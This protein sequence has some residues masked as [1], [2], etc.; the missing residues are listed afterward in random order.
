VPCEHGRVS[1]WV[2]LH[3]TPLTPAVWDSVAAHL[4]GAVVSPDCTRVPREPD[5][6]RLL[7]ETVSPS[8]PEGT[9]DVVGHSFGG[10]IALELALAY[11]S[12]VRSLTILCSRDTP[13]PAFTAVADAVR[14]GA[15]PTTTAG[16]ER[17][18]TA[19]EVSAD[20]PAVRAARS[21]LDEAA[22]APASWAN[23][24]DAIATY[25]RSTEVPALGM[26]VF[27]HAAA[28]DAVSTPSA[29]TAFAGRIPGA[30]LTVHEAW[31]HMS[32]FTAPADLAD[33]LR[34]ARTT[35]G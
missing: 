14:R 4:D 19:D 1:T 25:D 9:W 12:R 21:D 3:G 22:S 10:Q 13:V 16:V 23:A 15:G 20:G 30:V 7:A 24:L 2:L 31:A 18:F 32:A 35:R 33:L 29:M 34:V 28:H 8:L 27:L 6:Q 11:P 17:W 26:P 5:A